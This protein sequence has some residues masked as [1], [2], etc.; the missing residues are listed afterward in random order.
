MF[1][2]CYAPVDWTCQSDI[3]RQNFYVSYAF[4]LLCHGQNHLYPQICLFVFPTCPVG[5]DCRIHQL[6]LSR[7]VSL[8]KECPGFDTKQSDSESPIKLE[9]W[10]MRSTPSL[11]SLPGPHWPGV[12][13][14]DRVLS[15]GQIELNCLFMLNWIVWNRTISMH[16]N[17][18]RIK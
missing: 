7:G 10:G 16:K 11:P 14:P 6:F 1:S 9:F 15:M 4:F 3:R 8:L 2:I 13:A 5:W 12:V 18:F 17:E